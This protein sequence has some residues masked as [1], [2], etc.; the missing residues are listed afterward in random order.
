MRIGRAGK[1]L[2]ATCIFHAPKKSGVLAIK[3]LQGPFSG[4]RLYFPESCFVPE[5]DFF[6]AI[7]S[8]FLRL[9]QRIGDHSS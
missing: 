5:P 7:G 4:F 9:E 6:P 8:L 1:I 2:K 3:N